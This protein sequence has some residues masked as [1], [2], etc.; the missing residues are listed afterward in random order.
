MI[1]STLNAAAA[2]SRL[3]NGAAILKTLRALDWDT[4]GYYPILWIRT[5]Y[6]WIRT[7]TNYYFG[8]LPDTVDA[9]RNKARNLC[10]PPKPLVHVVGG[11]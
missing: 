3:I 7:D 9:P 2:S 6:C 5:G 11:W 4:P 8:Y 1:T 10:L